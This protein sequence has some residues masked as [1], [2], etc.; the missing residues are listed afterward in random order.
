MFSADS[1]R[2]HQEKMH[3]V[4][5]AGFVHKFEQLHQKYLKE[6]ILL[7]EKAIADCLAVKDG[8]VPNVNRFG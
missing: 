7:R 2:K 4:T 3:G 8:P 5:R 1:F 6:E